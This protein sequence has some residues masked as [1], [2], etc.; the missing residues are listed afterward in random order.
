MIPVF[1]CSYFL[2]S[3]LYL[4]HNAAGWRIHYFESA[5]INLF[6]VS[7]IPPN[8]GEIAYS[9][10]ALLEAIWMNKWIKFKIL[11]SGILIINK[12]ITLFITSEAYYYF[13]IEPLQNLVGP[14]R[15]VQCWFSKKFMD[16]YFHDLKIY[17]FKIEK[18]TIHFLRTPLFKESTAY[19]LLNFWHLLVTTDFLVGVGKS[20]PSGN[21]VGSLSITPDASFA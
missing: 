16:L 4:I 20:I 9:T 5:P 12:I 6:Q 15:D 11:M 3:K 8:I 10:L 19:M 14:I 7:S 13:E 18:I 17:F 21:T 2:N 1:H